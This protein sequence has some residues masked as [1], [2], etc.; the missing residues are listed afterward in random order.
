MI[1]VA[2]QSYD[3][4]SASPQDTVPAD[5]PLADSSRIVQSFGTRWHIQQQGDGPTLL[6]LHG[7]AAS[8]HSFRRLI[9][10]LAKHF[11]VIAVDLPG[12]GYSTRLPDGDMSLPAIARGLEGLFETLDVQPRFIA[13]HSAGA[14]IGLRLALDTGS[15]IEAVVGLNA[16]LLPYGGVFTRVFSPLASFFA[17][18]RL[19]PQLLA[20]RATN[21]RAVE[22]VI[23]GTGSVLDAEG[24]EL[25]R[26]LFRREA[27]LEAVLAMMAAWDLVPLTRD[28][29]TL[30]ARLLL[31]AGGRDRAVDPREADRVR[32]RLRRADVIR[33]EHC[34]HLA[35]EE[36]P[37]D[38]V[39]LIREHCLEAKGDGNA[40][41]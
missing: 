34:G 4:A 5:W 39:R 33:L 26:E 27:H 9:P 15:P 19:M 2:A 20:K 24:I 21:R 41:H 35:H 30:E 22:R 28:L 3:H 36:A 12:H 29:P 23:R 7:T 6:L 32:S 10:E 13:G 25:Y 18:T 8:T 17:S 14:A 38:V 16:A 1:S 11:S 31:V 40:E 37:D